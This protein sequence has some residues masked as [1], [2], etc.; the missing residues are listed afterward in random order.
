[1]AKTKK[2]QAFPKP[3]LPKRL[4]V[5]VENHQKALPI[6]KRLIQHIACRLCEYLGVEREHLSIYFV[7]EK[8]I[9]SLHDRFFQD[10]TPTDCIS[11]PMEAPYLGEIIICPSVAIAY[12]AAHN[13]DPY[14]ETILYLV[15]GLLHL[16]GYDDL[17]PKDRKVM[18]KMET[19]CINHL[20]SIKILK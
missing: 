17:S 12:A 15:H 11:F 9:S 14:R 8:K 2:S 7:T 10:P 1:M 18:R 20:T 5:H 3:L 4:R 13:L 6:R 16:I 19:K